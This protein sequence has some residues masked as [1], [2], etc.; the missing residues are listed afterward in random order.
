MPLTWPHVTADSL[1]NS[2]TVTSYE[3]WRSTKAYFAL[4]SGAP[5]TIRLPDALPP[6]GSTVSTDD[7]GVLTGGISYYYLI[8]AVAGSAVSAPSNQ[9]GTFSFGIVPGGL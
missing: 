4:E 6:F 1:G 8:R 3:V 5:A 9:V 7:G 2:V